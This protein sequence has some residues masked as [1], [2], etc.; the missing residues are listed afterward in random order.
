MPKGYE[1]LRVPEGTV[2]LRAERPE[3][4]PEDAPFERYFVVRDNLRDLVDKAAE[5]AAPVLERASTAAHRTI[6]KVT[7]M[8]VP[9]VDWASQSGKQLAARSPRWPAIIARD[10]VALRASSALPR[11][12]NVKV[13]AQVATDL[14]AFAID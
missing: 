4:L 10:R 7:D 12:P 11:A 1:I 14:R 8:A 6:D 5:K 13:A 3:N 2:V 9:A